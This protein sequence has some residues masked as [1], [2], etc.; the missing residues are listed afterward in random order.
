MYLVLGKDKGD[1]AI[2]SDVRLD[3][4]ALNLAID[5]DVQSNLHPPELES[6]LGK[7]NKVRERKNAH[8]HHNKGK[9]KKEEEE[10]EGQLQLVQ[11]QT[12]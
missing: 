9:G 8:T 10:E 11:N 4:E 1:E 6:R 2:G 7:H 5:G 12:C 3:G